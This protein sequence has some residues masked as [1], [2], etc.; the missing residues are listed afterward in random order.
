MAVKSDN[1]GFTLTKNKDG[2]IIFHKIFKKEGV[3]LKTVEKIVKDAK[4]AAE[5]LK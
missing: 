2:D 5:L 3:N 1:E 4:K